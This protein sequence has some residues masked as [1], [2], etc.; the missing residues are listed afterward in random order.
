[1]DCKFLKKSSK[2]LKKKALKVAWSNGEDSSSSEEEFSKE[3]KANL[4]LMA[5]ED[6]VSDD[7]QIFKFT[8]EELYDAFNDLLGDYKK[9]S[10][11]NKEP[12]KDNQ[13][14]SKDKAKVENDFKES[15]SELNK[16]IKRNESL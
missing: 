6:E 4:Y 3:E 16:L 8:F 5:L 9:L 11:K 10:H 2:K 7:D 15:Q 1:M 14:L 12:K 13:S